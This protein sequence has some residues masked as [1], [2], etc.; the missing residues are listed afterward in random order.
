V[1]GLRILVADDHPAFRR[2]LAGMLSTVEDLEVV[3]DA[4]DGRL[5][6]ERTVELR[7]DVV[8]MD[9]NMPVVGGIEA[10]AEIVARVPGT[11]VLALTMIEDDEMLLSAL[12]AGAS[13]YLLKG[14]DQDD[15]VRAVRA[16]AA[17]EMI[18]GPGI[19]ERVRQ[20]LSRPAI[21]PAVD[22]PFPQLTDR[23]VEI[24][25]LLASGL[26]NP[27]IAH[28]LVVSEKTVRNHVSNVFAKLHVDRARAIIL[29]RDAGLGRH[30]IEKS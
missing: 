28:R 5:A 8:L 13:G 20:L 14:A 11:V 18:F 12:R 15:V 21:D 10:T 23:E 24:L 19:A 6:V 22:R 2:G 1:G 4:P 30:A 29:A 16:A 7:P 3:G 17:G 27:Q 25:D 9:L 26:R